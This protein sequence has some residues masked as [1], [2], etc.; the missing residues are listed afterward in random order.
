MF[1]FLQ[2]EYEYDSTARKI[3]FTLI[4]LVFLGFG[5]LIIFKPGLISQWVA[6]I[7]VAVTTK[8]VQHLYDHAFKKRKNGE[9]K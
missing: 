6:Y 2:E 4:A 5:A 8:I 7:I 9:K 3:Y 1:A